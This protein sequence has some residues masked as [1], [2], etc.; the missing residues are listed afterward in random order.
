MIYP[1]TKGQNNATACSRHPG[2]VLSQSLVWEMVWFLPVVATMTLISGSVAWVYCR[3]CR[4]EQITPLRFRQEYHP[5]SR[6]TWSHPRI[7]SGTTIKSRLEF[8]AA[9]ARRPTVSPFF[10]IKTGYSAFGLMAQL[11][12]QTSWAMFVSGHRNLCQLGQYPVLD[13]L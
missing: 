5:S 4:Q 8:F 2:R 12:H 7:I 1:R 3:Q 6:I 9:L 13:R 10:A 11:S